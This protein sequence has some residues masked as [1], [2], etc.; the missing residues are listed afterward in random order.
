[1]AVH[2]VYAL[3]PDMIR[4]ARI[5]LLPGDPFRSP[6]IAHA[7]AEAYG[8]SSPAQPV[9]H[10]REYCTYLADIPGAVLL[11][12]STGIGGP[13]TSIAIEELAHLRVDTF[14]RVGTTGAIQNYIAIGDWSSQQRRSVS[15]APR[16]STRRSSIPLSRIMTC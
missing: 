7:L 12:T 13:S 9:A 1:M 8:V 3:T 2:E 11:V 15:M 4:G 6:K 16:F 5:V 14:I 10:K